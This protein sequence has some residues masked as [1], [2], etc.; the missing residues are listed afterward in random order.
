MR[1]IKQIFLEGKKEK[2]TFAVK[3]A[4]SVTKSPKFPRGAGI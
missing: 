2:S 1:K 4:P 3:K